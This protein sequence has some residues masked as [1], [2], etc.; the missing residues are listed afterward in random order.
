[1]SATPTSALSQNHPAERQHPSKICVITSTL[2]EVHIKLSLGKLL[3]TT[4]EKKK[5]H[6]LLAEYEF[7]NA[8]EFY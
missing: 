8:A 5:T 7:L 4:P 3:Q 2:E 6:L 1:M